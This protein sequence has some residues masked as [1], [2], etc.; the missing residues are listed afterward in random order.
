MATGASTAD[1]ALILI[2]ARKGLLA[3]T[4]RHTY[5]CHL[6]GIKRIICVINK[7]DL[8]QYKESKFQEIVLNY[9]LFTSNIGVENQATFQFLLYMGTMLYRSPKI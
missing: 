4:K 7:M 9:E 5:L 2:D 1:A 3:Q 8:V 6:F